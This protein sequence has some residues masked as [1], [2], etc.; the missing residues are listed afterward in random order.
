[1]SNVEPAPALV[2]CDSSGPAG[3]ELLVGRDVV[4]GGT[5]AMS[6]TTSLSR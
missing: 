4:L 2:V 1:M 3:P 6:V 5:G